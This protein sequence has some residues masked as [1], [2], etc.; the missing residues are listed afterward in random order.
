[1][2]HRC[3]EFL[4]SARRNRRY[5]QPSPYGCPCAGERVS[6]RYEARLP[7][8]DSDLSLLN[9]DGSGVESR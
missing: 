8:A 3:D 9:W 6:R 5:T 7:A 1:M 2:L 4:A